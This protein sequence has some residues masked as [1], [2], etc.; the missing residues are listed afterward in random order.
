MKLPKKV[1]ILG[2]TFRVTFTDDQNLL[3]GSWGVADVKYCF[4]LIDKNLPPENR[5]ATLMHEMDEVILMLVNQKYEHRDF[6]DYAEKRFAVYRDNRMCFNLDD[7][8]GVKKK[9]R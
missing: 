2:R 7:G 4:I 1:R 9:N 3:R 6:E 5:L 8:C